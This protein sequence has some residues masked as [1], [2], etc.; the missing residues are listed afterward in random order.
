M[1]LQ[2][3]LLRTM[4]PINTSSMREKMKNLTMHLHENEFR[5]TETGEYPTKHMHRFIHNSKIVSIYLISIQ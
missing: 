4:R 5:K 2:A 3:L 1:A